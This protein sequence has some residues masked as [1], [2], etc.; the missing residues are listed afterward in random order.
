MRKKADSCLPFSPFVFTFLLRPPQHT[1]NSVKE[2]I[3]KRREALYTRIQAYHRGTVGK[4]THE[5]EEQK[6][7]QKHTQKKLLPQP[8]HHPRAQRHTDSQDRHKEKGNLNDNV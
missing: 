5:A 2:E 1:P 4:Q 6:Q 7:K 8:I 3:R